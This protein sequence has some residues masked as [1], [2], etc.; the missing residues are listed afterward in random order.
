[1][2]ST[3]DLYMTLFNADESLTARIELLAKANGLFVR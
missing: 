1:M 3:D 2:I